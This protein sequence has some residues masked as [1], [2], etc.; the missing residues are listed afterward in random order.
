M[1][2]ITAHALTNP[3]RRID[4]MRKEDG[5]SDRKIMTLKQSP[6]PK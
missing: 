4:K 1:F 5:E 3:L 2:G 6:Q